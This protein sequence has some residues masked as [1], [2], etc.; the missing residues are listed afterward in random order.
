MYIP[1]SSHSCR[2]WVKYIV[3]SSPPNRLLEALVITDFWISTSLVSEIPAWEWAFSVESWIA[4]VNIILV[5]GPIF[6]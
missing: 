1:V 6:K 4:F 3:K 2:L 5:T